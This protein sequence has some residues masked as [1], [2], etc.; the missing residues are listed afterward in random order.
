MA[1][2]IPANRAEVRGRRGITTDSRAVIAGNAFVA[3]RGERF[4]GH[5]FLD[6]AMDRGATLLVVERGRAPKSGARSGVEVLE[7]DDTL[8]A[9]GDLARDHRRRWG[10]KIV[11]VT[12]S[13]GKTTTKEIT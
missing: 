7:V 8:A 5:A 2:P 12:G 3:L 11:A 4:D 13:A 10:G 6:Q 1:T 9:W